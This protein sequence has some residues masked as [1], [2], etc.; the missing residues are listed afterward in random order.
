M[1]QIDFGQTMTGTSLSEPLRLESKV[2]M[3]GCLLVSL[4]VHSKASSKSLLTE[5]SHG[6]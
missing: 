4:D 1:P 3:L 2:F 6:V 5:V